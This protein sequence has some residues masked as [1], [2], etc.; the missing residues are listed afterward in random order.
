MDFL[1]NPFHTQ[2]IAFGKNLLKRSNGCVDQLANILRQQSGHATYRAFIHAA[3]EDQGI[4]LFSG[5]LPPILTTRA[6]VLKAQI[7]RDTGLLA[8]AEQ[9]LEKAKGSL[10]SATEALRL[11]DPVCFCVCVSMRSIHA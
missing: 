5:N 6:R 11:A 8:P 4:P 7:R 2:T 1:D 9:R 3:L 10:E